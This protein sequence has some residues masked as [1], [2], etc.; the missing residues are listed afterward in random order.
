MTYIPSDDILEGLYQLRIRESEK[1]KTVLELF[2]MENHQKKLGLDYHRLKAMVKWSIEQ[3]IRNENF[4]ARSGNFEKNAVVKNQGTKQ[5]GQRTLGDIW[6]W[7]TNGQ[8]PE[9]DNCSF[10]RDVNQGAKLTQPNLSPR[11]FMQQI[12]RNVSRTR[13]PRGKSPSG[14]MSRWPCK[15]YVKG[16]CTNSFYEKWHPPECL[17]YKSKSGCRFGETC[18]YAHRQVDEQPSKRC[19]ENDDKIAVAMLKKIGTKAYGNLLSTVTKVTSDRGDPISS[20]LLVMIWNED[21]LDVD[22]QAHDNWVVSFRTWKRIFT[23]G[24]NVI[25]VTYIAPVRSH[26]WKHLI[27]RPERLS[28]FKCYCGLSSQVIT[29][30]VRTIHHR[31]WVLLLCHRREGDLSQFQRETARNSLN[32][33]SSFVTSRAPD[34]EPHWTRVLVFLC[35]GMSFQPHSTVTE[36][37]GIHDSFRQHEVWHPQIFCFVHQRLAVRC[38]MFQGAGKRLCKELTTSAPASWFLRWLLHQ[39]MSTM[40]NRSGP[41]HAAASGNVWVLQSRFENDVLLRA[42]WLLVLITHLSVCLDHVLV[43]RKKADTVHLGWDWKAKG[44]REQKSR[45]STTF[46]GSHCSRL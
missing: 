13:S 41:T 21:L 36:A 37:S 1:L 17:F 5:R 16:I 10:R 11:S 12:E 33:L 9:G 30:A 26:R 38:V 6:Q 39:M 2:H 15:D 44:H 24:S 4:G 32:E 45:L 43:K 8:F 19:H 28:F 27:C 25:A 14:R 22:H 35:V 29:S 18:S 7:K 42:T 31:A 40:P 46:V 23:P 20:V 3:E 34:E